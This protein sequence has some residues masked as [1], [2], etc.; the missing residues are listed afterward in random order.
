MTKT[1][2]NHLKKACLLL[3]LCFFTFLPLSVSAQTF[4]ERIQKSEKGEGTVTI[5]QDKSIENLVNGPAPT[6]PKKKQNK[7]TTATPAKKTQQP[8]QQEEKRDTT[9]TGETT[10]TQEENDSVDA[11]PKRTYRTVGYRVQVYAGGNKR[12]DR[13]KA[14][15]AGRTLR[16]LFPGEEVYVHFYSPRWICRM[17][18]Y[19]TYEEAQEKL[20]A[21]RRLGFSSATIVKGKITLAQP[22]N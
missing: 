19:R 16:G 1:F 15:Q 7:T 22:Y 12:Q 18:N 2:S 6:A 14:E 8:T 20:E 9:Q 10:D 21:V 17:G 4:T 5:H 11:T 13:Q 3:P